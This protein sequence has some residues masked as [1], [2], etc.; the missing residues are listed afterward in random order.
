MN[1]RDFLGTLLPTTGF[2]FTASPQ[3]KAAP[4][5]GKSILIW[6]NVVHET[7]DEAAK[8]VNWLTYQGRDAY[9]AMASY[10]EKKVWDANAKTGN[11]SLGKWRTRTQDNAQ[12]I[13]S[14]YLDLDVNPNDPDKFATKV[15]ALRELEAFRIK[16][17][18]PEP[19][20]VD[21]GGGYHIYWP[22]AHEVSTDEWRPVAGMLKA[23]CLRERFKADRSLTSDQARVLR[24]LGSFNFKPAVL[25]T[26]RLIIPAPRAYGFKEIASILETYADDHQLNIAAPLPTQAQLAGQQANGFVDNLGTTNDP[27]EFDRIAFACPQ[28]G[29]QVGTRGQHTGEKLWRATLGIVKF[30]EPMALAYRA[31]SDSHP[32]YDE[33]ATVSK[34]DAWNAGPTTCKHF[35]QENPTVCDGCSYQG[36]ITS[37]IV[38]GK[39]IAE[40]PPPTIEL[41]DEDGVTEVVTILAPPHPYKR[42]LDGSIATISESKDCLELV[43]TVCPNDLYPMKLLRQTGADAEIKERTIWRA[44]LSTPKDAS[45]MIVDF[46]ISQSMVADIRTL[47]SFLS[48]KGFQ[49]NPDQIKTTQQ[50]MSAYLQHLA[51]EASREKVYERLGWHDDHGTFSLGA[52]AIHNDGKMKPHDMSKNVERFTKKSLHAKGTLEGWKAAMD[53][54]KGPGYEAHRIF[55]YGAFGAPLFHMD[56]TGNMGVMVS[57]AGASGRGK[58]TCLKACASVWGSSKFIL[59][60]N[61]AGTTTNALYEAIATIHSL[62]VYLDDTTERDVQDMKEMYLNVSTG[63]GK[64]RML[65]GETVS[66]KVLEWMT[67]I[68][69]TTNVDG[70]QAMQNQGGG[71]DPHTRRLV[72]V[73]FEGI[74][75]DPESKIAADEFLRALAENYGHAGPLYMRHVV[76]NYA[77]IKADYITSINTI[78]RTINST[79]ASAERFWVAFVACCHRGAKIAESLGLLTGFPIE[80]DIKWMIG[81]LD[82]QRGQ[83]ELNTR[84]PLDVLNSFLHK[85]ESCTLVLQSKGGNLDRIVREPSQSLYIHHDMDLGVIWAS[86]DAIKDYCRDTKQDFMGIERQ[87]LRAKVIDSARTLKVL[88]AD[89][90]RAKGQSA[91]WKINVPKLGPQS[92]VAPVPPAAPVSNVVPITGSK[93]A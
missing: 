71:S 45:P 36:N 82:R 64:T 3:K 87:L 46:T 77:K 25:A 63:L 83:M 55:L 68:F 32:E 91:C 86:R 78:T 93:A 21:S 44:H 38:L 24:A 29:I 40:A 70:M 34:I 42:Q 33:S 14:F 74:K 22:L 35:E 16:V 11:G 47:W 50:Y 76:P 53:F 52:V 41:I 20:I 5:G 62:P 88:G 15:D 28:V 7:L 8:H 2:F 60:G 54:Y 84:T 10:K 80:K 4:N 17:G 39:R 69:T 19:M 59:N 9:F 12:S 81:S 90:V 65:D 27:A 92:A 31:V 58:T 72:Q 66:G 57:A 79:D 75:T 13:K 61:K 89:T 73:E 43:V 48:D 56:D 23:I 49:V 6:H 37:P 26:V 67:P 1:V 85:F 18:L 51:R 30:C